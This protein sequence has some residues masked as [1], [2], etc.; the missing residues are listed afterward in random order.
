MFKPSDVLRRHRVILLAGC[1][2]GLSVAH[3]LNDFVPDALGIGVGMFC[4]GALS[5]FVAGL[6]WKGKA[7]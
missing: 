7:P 1:A 4:T 5:G 3:L 2:A 6:L